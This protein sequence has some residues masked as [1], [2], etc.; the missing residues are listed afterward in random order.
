MKRFRVKLGEKYANGNS[1]NCE[2][3]E[4]T[5]LKHEPKNQRRQ[6]HKIW[7]KPKPEIEMKK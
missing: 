2:N 1:K 5:I 7:R 3:D 6:Q 4:T